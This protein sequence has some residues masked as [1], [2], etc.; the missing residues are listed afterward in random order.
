MAGHDVCACVGQ[1]NA[2]HINEDSRIC[3]V[4]GIER[5]EYGRP[6]GP[7]TLRNGGSE[8]VAFVIIPVPPPTSSQK[9]PL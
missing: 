9:W 6:F 5:S 8:D 3:L 7:A 1:L 2:G 4:G